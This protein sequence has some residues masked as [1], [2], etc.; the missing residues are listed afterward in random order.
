MTKSQDK[1]KNWKV[2]LKDLHIIDVIGITIFF[3]IISLTALFFLRKQATVDVVLRVSESGSLDIWYKPPLWYLDN[4]KPNVGES[5]WLG[6]RTIYIKNV[7]SF[8]TNQTN[9]LFY[10]TISLQAAFNKRLNQYSYNGV[11]LLIG[12]YQTFKLQGV[13]ITGVIQNLGQDIDKQVQKDFIV[14]GY[15]DPVANDPSAL[16]ANSISDGIH[17]FLA[18][19][20]TTGLKMKD[21]NGQTIAEVLEVNKSL[22]TRQFIYQDRLIKAADENNERVELKLRLNARQFGN[23]YFFMNEQP[24]LINALLPLDFNSFG[25][26]LRVTDLQSIN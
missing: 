13:Q 19:Q 9:R 6:R 16:V 22:A 21:S 18:D 5:D 8:Y 7:N 26:S 24:L 17:K 1:R 2:I 14:K 4:L 25:A 15:L 3:V 12:S 23:L 11:P 20:F 10:I